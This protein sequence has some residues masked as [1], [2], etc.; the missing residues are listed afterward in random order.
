MKAFWVSRTGVIPYDRKTHFSQLWNFLYWA[1]GGDGEE[2]LI[3]GNGDYYSIADDGVASHRN[4]FFC[5]RR[6]GYND[7]GRLPDGVG[8]GTMSGG[9]SWKSIG[10]GVETPIDLRPRIKAALMPQDP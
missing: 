10:F 2:L 8:N 7:P 4:L 9:L 6:Y 3:A 1:D 5:F